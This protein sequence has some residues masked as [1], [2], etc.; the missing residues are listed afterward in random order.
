MKI[1]KKMI[2]KN[3]CNFWT[4][5]YMI[6]IAG[7]WKI[8]ERNVTRNQSVYKSEEEEEEEWGGGGEEKAVVK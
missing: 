7:E 3:D 2:K 5:E 6:I 1:K 4:L 8:Y